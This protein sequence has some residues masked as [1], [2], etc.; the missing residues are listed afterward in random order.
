[1]SLGCIYRSR[2]LLYTSYFHIFCVLGTFCGRKNVNWAVVTSNYQ[3]AQ[4]RHQRWWWWGCGDIHCW[5]WSWILIKFSTNFSQSF[6]GKSTI[7]TLLHKSLIEQFN[8]LLVILIMAKLHSYFW[9]RGEK[10]PLSIFSNPV[11]FYQINSLINLA[12]SILNN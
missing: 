1:M 11:V 2:T 12:R 4:P 7:L 10:E 6:F 3:A 8:L 5:I 9:R